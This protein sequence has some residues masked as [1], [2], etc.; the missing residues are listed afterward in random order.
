MHEGYDLLKDWDETV[1]NWA[2]PGSRGENLRFF[3]FPAYFLMGLAGLAKQGMLRNFLEPWGLSMPEWRLLSTV[4][5]CS[6]IRFSR[7]AQLTAMDKAQVSRALRTA[8]GKGLVES[9]VL[10]VE[11]AGRGPGKPASAGRVHV[12]ITAAGREVFA[13]VMPAVQGDQFQLL[14]LMSPEERRILIRLAR[15]MFAQ[16]KGGD[17]RDGAGRGFHAESGELA[18]AGGN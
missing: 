5:E 11:L 16:L 7:I 9:S 2:N 12:S 1:K 4:A 8:Q 18:I 14:A 6:P 15:R 3:D 13:K 17:G 10:E